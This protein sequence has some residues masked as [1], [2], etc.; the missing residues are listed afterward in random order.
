[1][2]IEEVER[3]EFNDVAKKEV[4]GAGFITDNK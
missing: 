3:M 1:M 2:G 4:D